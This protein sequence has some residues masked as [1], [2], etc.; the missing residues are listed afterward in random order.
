M[1][2]S[3]G[4]EDLEGVGGKFMS[5]AHLFR[6]GTPLIFASLLE[7]NESTDW[8]KVTWVF[9]ELLLSGFDHFVQFH[10]HH[11]TIGIGSLSLWWNGEK[12]VSPATYL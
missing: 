8:P 2:C 10:L 5:T 12:V 1:R 7:G 9:R 3:D 6:Q 4:L 11:A